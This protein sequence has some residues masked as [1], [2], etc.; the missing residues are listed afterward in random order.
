MRLRMMILWYEDN[1][2]DCQRYGSADS[3]R[4]RRIRW[5]LL[6]LLTARQSFFSVDGK[7]VSSAERRCCGWNSP[8]RQ[9][10]LA[11]PSNTI[12]TVTKQPSHAP[13]SLPTGQTVSF[14]LPRISPGHPI[15]LGRVN[16]IRERSRSHRGGQYRVVS[17]PSMN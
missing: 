8:S 12:C 1:V 9:S 5:Y 15:A 4:L 16:A 7:S 3:I 10:A 11:V 14:S 13:V 2:L 17:K 6:I